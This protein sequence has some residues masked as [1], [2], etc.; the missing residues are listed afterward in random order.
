[1]SASACTR[2]VPGSPCAAVADSQTLFKRHIVISFLLSLLEWM[3]R[4]AS[5][6]PWLG[7]AVSRGFH[8]IDL[9]EKSNATDEQDRQGSSSAYS[10][11]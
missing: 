8:F 2:S 4:P 9:F 1:M 10:D 6:V 7:S 11:H 5:D 3:I